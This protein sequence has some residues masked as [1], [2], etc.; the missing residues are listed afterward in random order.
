MT[1]Q[2]MG[3][4][5]YMAPEQ[6]KGL[7]AEITVATDV[8]GL[9]AILYYLLT[10]QSPFMSDSMDGVLHRVGYDEPVAPHALNPG[11]PRDLD[12]VCLK[13][14]QKEP[15]KRYATAQ[16]VADDLTRFRRGEPIQARR[17]SA[18]ERFWRWCRRRPAIAGLLLALHVV[19]VAGLTGVL[20][21]LA[22]ARRAERHTTERLWESYLA[23]ARGSRLSNRPGRR[24]DSLEVLAKAAAIKPTS[25]LRDE[26][27]AC[28]ALSDVRMLCARTNFGVT[29]VRPAFD[30][31]LER[32]AAAEASG[33]VVIRQVNDG[34]ELLRLPA[35]ETGVRCI[36]QFSP[37]GGLLSVLYT[38]GLVKVW[39]LARREILFTGRCIITYGGMGA[40]FTPDEKAIALANGQMR[41]A[42]FDLI[43]GA[44]RNDWP[45]SLKAGLLRF[46]PDG[47]RL[48]VAEL[49]HELVLVLDGRSGETL[50]ALSAPGG[51]RALSWNP[52]GRLLAIASGDRRIR[53]Y[54]TEAGMER[55]QLAGHNADI[56]ELAFSPTAPLLVTAAWD[57]TSFWNYETSE[58]LFSIASVELIL[59]FAQDG[60]RLTC[61]RPWPK[62]S[63]EIYEVACGFPVRAYGSKES[64]APLQPVKGFC[65]AFSPDGRLLAYASAGKL[66]FFQSRT[67]NQLAC[68]V[69][70]PVNSMA[71]DFNTNLWLSGSRGLFCLPQRI[72]AAD[73]ILEFGP[74]APVGPP[75]AMSGLV[76]SADGRTFG[77]AYQ[78][79]CLIF[80]TMTRQQVARTSPS[81]DLR[82]LALSPDGRLAAT[83]AWSGSNL[84]IWDARTGRFL[85]GLEE[86][87][88]P[89]KRCDMGFSGDGRFF[90]TVRG[91]CSLWDVATW[92]RRWRLPLEI[93]HMATFSPD[94]RL[95]AARNLN[96]QV[97]L[98]A[99]E[100]GRTL[101]NL[102]A[103]GKHH[104]WSLVFSPDSTRLAVECAGTQELVVWDLRGIRGRLAA[105]GLDWDQPPDLRVEMIPR[106]R[107][108]W[109]SFRTRLKGLH[110]GKRRS[111][112]KFFQGS[113]TRARC[114]ST[115]PTNTILA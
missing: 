67:G 48:A 1:G 16:A 52:T 32:Y 108:E 46:S 93:W 41:V 63:F 91:S 71:F 3:T 102:E 54:D 69:V 22:R 47:S 4:P 50:E 70:G 104:P 58:H 8:Y 24:F 23:Q 45:V 62:A 77:V 21:E 31:G 75:D 9:G 101:A 25:Q 36:G 17:V 65:S 74:P 107:F 14:M 18:A 15:A 11:V 43:T 110:G 20:W 2:V 88:E 100:T 27:I 109:S 68:M 13:C 76:A 37:S 44:T 33:D 111:Q 94:S 86:E 60:K 82:W 114:S 35:Q 106:V 28:M 115:L 112:C 30:A 49:Y 105:M 59:Q 78:N 83:G 53:L 42:V 10:A 64:G 113:L 61:C 26:A 57:G 89:I 95:L 34:R 72:G 87:G 66:Q 29:T 99:V 96:N 97:C 80:D 103:P 84:S 38:N 12:T 85:H 79:R 40:A 73:G 98:L 55:K 90:V 39:N 7:R 5:H 19:L 51:L 81:G 92:Q 56:E 6:A